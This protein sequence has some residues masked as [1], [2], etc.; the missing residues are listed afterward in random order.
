MQIRPYTGDDAA[1]W[2]AFCDDAYMSTFLHTRRFLSYHG[3][4]FRDLSLVIEDAGDWLGVLPAALHPED[5]ACVVSHPGITYG[6]LLHTGRLRGERMVE[7]IDS[8]CAYYARQGMERFLYKAV[9]SIYHAAPAQD[10]L[11]A[12]FRINAVR[13]RCDL[14]SSI[15]LANRLPRSER[16][17]RSF[18]KALKAGVAVG[19]A[20]DEEVDS[21]WDVLRE[22]LG[23]K[24]EAK[25][26]HTLREI[27]TL[28]GRF[29]GNIEFVV[30]LLDGRVEAGVVLFKTAT[31]HHA[32]YIA[33]SLLANRHAL[34]DAVFEYCIEN[35]IQGGARYFD[36]GISN[37]K[38]GRELNQNLFRFKSE[39][40]GGGTVHE[41]YEV[42]L[43]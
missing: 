21:F 35:A 1:Q 20:A 34:Q 17:K 28:A 15:D 29:P 4:R 38:Q 7:A 26:V 33:A 19:N 13:R 16:R 43:K 2:D 6:G 40:G 14:S 18:R 12:L 36:F 39:F 41:F 24:H 27:K 22:N 25:P 5:Q 9:P 8:I 11:Y 23:R 10:D 32:Q 42:C 30:A 3:E 37:E 31:V